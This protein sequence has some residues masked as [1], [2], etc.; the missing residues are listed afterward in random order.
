[1]SMDK[2]NNASLPQPRNLDHARQNE[3]IDPRQQPQP[4]TSVKTDAS[5]ALGSVPAGGDT[6]QISEA[7]HRLME[8]RQAVDSGRLVLDALPDVRQDKIALARTRLRTGFYQ[9]DVVRDKVAE[10]V[11]R[12]IES[13]ENL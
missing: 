3:R 11:G 12:S 8:L 2:I 4:P 5:G 7:A 1:M 10:G 9:P 13:L 6:A